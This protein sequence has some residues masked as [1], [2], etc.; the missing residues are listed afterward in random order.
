MRATFFETMPRV[1][2]HRGASGL[3][4]ENTIASFKKAAEVGTQ[5]IEIDVMITSDDQC[6]ICHDTNV[7]RCT[8]GTGPVLLKTLEE[9]KFLDAGK[10]FSGAFAGQQI[11]TLQE[12]TDLLTKLNMSLNLEI[13]PTDG[14]EVPT[15]KI[16]GQEL[17]ANLP[18]DLPVLLSSFNIEALVTT[19]EI[20]PHLPRG[21]LS[22]A[23]PYEWERRLAEARVDS[24]HC[25][26]NFVTEDAIK[27][28]Q[29]AGYRFLAFTVNDPAHAKQLLDWNIDA[30]ITDYPDRMLPLL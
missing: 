17:K 13:K 21:Y 5:S 18:S 23:I 15:A 4:P 22:D 20:V 25:D 9:I 29:D 8:D 27:A 7:N 30:I 1:I 6:V 14:W 26:A 3:A 28:V 24:L 11:P 2:G 12:T 16:V 10:W 19:G